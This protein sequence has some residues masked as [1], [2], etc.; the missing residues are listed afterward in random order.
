MI[1]P[2]YI[3][4]YGVNVTRGVLRAAADLGAA[5]NQNLVRSHTFKQKHT[6]RWYRSTTISIRTQMNS[7]CSLRR[8]ERRER[9][10]CV[11]ASCVFRAR[12]R[13]HARASRRTATTQDG[14]RGQIRATQ[15][16]NQCSLRVITPRFSLS[17]SL[18]LFL[19]LGQA[20][21]FK[22]VTRI[23]TAARSTARHSTA[24]PYYISLFGVAVR[25][26][27]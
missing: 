14:G 26:M 21:C 11:P 6:S 18:S 8:R 19:S 16:N 27:R 1:F 22:G 17:L 4:I 15:R 23:G 10:A 3:L 9:R 24:L 13:V 25:P 7:S 20:D 2:L 12:E 5:G